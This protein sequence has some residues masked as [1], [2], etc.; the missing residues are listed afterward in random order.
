MNVPPQL[1]R[2]GRTEPTGSAR[3]SER[4]KLLPPKKFWAPVTV[5]PSFSAGGVGVTGL[6]VVPAVH[7]RN[8]GSTGVNRDRLPILS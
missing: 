3:R 2:S 4:P 8:T 5:G 7:E 1:V 6:G